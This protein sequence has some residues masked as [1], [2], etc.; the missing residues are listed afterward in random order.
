MKE[1]FVPIINDEFT[2]IYGETF[3]NVQEVAYKKGELMGNVG[4]YI[5]E[6]L[7]IKNAFFIKSDNSQSGV[8]IYQD[9][10]DPF[11]AYRIY[12]E[13]ADYGFNGYKDD[14]LIS[15]LR[16]LQK[17]IKLTTFPIGVV[18]LEGR[19]IGQKIPFFE[20]YITLFDYSLISS[21]KNPVSLYKNVLEIIEEMYK[22]G[23]LYMDNH[24]GN[25][26]INPKNDPNKIEAIDFEDKYMEFGDI[27]RESKYRVLHNFKE[28]IEL[29][30]ENFGVYDVLGKFIE[31]KSFD[32]GYIQLEEMSKKL[33]KIRS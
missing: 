6:T 23:I 13:F 19:I 31:I 12:K 14:S 26:L 8:Y 3:D 22:K 28:M 2:N 7:P 32:D 17:E 1:N 20:D 24:P 33:V 25:F 18:T 4:K 9:R 29:L 5:T 16:K 15:K 27:D 10:N 11:S 21:E 30:N